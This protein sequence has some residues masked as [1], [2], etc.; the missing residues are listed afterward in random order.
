MSAFYAKPYWADEKKFINV[1]HPCEGAT[2]R[3][4]DGDIFKYVKVEKPHQTVWET[5]D[6]AVFEWRLEGGVMNLKLK[7]IH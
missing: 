5:P 4:K 7:T 6:N 3:D 1:T 2:F